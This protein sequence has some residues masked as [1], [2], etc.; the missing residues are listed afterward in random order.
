MYKLRKTYRFEASH[1]LKHHDGKCRHLH[2]H[3]WVVTIEVK[4]PHMIPEGP[5]TNMVVDFGVISEIAKPAVMEMDH[6]HLNEFLETDSPTSE[7]VCYYLRRA[8][9][10][11]FR[12]HNIIL[13]AIEVEE[14]C[15]S[16][17]RYEF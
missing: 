10:E 7:Y 17:V 5:K 4:G 8:L 2:G 3:S 12:S 14:T 13:C 16:E 9:E 15:T 11:E 6:T 1:Q